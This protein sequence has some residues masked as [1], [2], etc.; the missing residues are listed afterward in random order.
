MKLPTTAMGSLTTLST[1]EKQQCGIENV[2]NNWPITVFQPFSWHKNLCPFRPLS[3]ND[4]RC[5][6]L[7]TEEYVDSSSPTKCQLTPSWGLLPCCLFEMWSMAGDST[8]LPF[9]SMRKDGFFHRGFPLASLPPRVT[10]DGSRCICFSLRSEFYFYG[11]AKR[12]C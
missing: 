10:R 1:S 12:C 9:N 11:A 3:H 5:E 7:S 6:Q 2:L 8:W 4:S